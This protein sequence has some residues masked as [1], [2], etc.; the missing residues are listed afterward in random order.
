MPSFIS[1]G[2]VLY[3]YNRTTYSVVFSWENSSG[4]RISFETY[5]GNTKSRIT[6]EDSEL[7]NIFLRGT[8]APLVRQTNEE[9]SIIWF[10][11]NQYN[12]VTTPN[13]EIAI[14]I[15]ESVKFTKY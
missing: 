12:I 9:V 8:I 7:S 2:Y 6:S 13:E 11:G 1:E 5:G 14:K 3:S 10:E 4:D 15:A